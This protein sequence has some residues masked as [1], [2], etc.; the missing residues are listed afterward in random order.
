MV[1]VKPKD[2]GGLFR[3]NGTRRPPTRPYRPS[4]PSTSTEWPDRDERYRNAITTAQCEALAAELGVTP[5]ALREI[6]VGWATY[7]ELRSMRASFA[8][9]DGSYPD[10]AFTFPERDGNGRIVGLSLRATDGRKGFPAGARRGLIVP[11]TLKNQSGDVLVV[12]GATDVAGCLT[13][14]VPA[15]GRPSNASGAADLATL[16]DSRPTLIVGERDQK[17]DGRYPGRDGAKRVAQQLAATWETS[18]FWTLPPDAVK[19]IRTWLQARVAAGL[20]LAD[21]EACKTA[22]AELVSALVAARKPVKPKR[23]SQAEGVVRLAEELFRIGLSDSREPFAVARD[24]PNV[25]LMFRGSSSA[26]R[27]TLAREYRRRTGRTP[28]ASGLADA[29]VAL[30]GA[31]MECTPETVHLRVAEHDGEIV[32]DLGDADGRAV[33]VADGHWYIAEKSPILFRRTA[34]TGAMPEPKQG[35]DI[36]ALRELLNVDDESWPLVLGWLV[37]ALMP[38]IPHP[39]L[40]FGGEQGTGKSTAARMAVGLI[41]PSPA[42]LRSQPKDERDWAVTAAGSWAVAVDNVSGISGWWSDALCRAVTGDGWVARQL[43]SDAGISV[44]SFRRVIALSSIAAGALRGDLGDRL[45]IVD[46][47]PIPD[48]RRLTE[49]DLSGRYEHLLPDLLGGLLNLLAAVWK[50]LPGLRLDTLPRMADFGRVLAAMDETLSTAALAT[51]LGQRGRIAVDVIESDLVG[52]AIRTLV[53]SGPWSGT[54]GELLERIKPERTSPE[55]P[56]SPTGMAARIKR[57][58]PALRTV[59]ITVSREKIGRDRSRIYR[60]QK[61]EET[62]VRNVPPSANGLFD[63]ENGDSSRT[64]AD[65]LAECGHFDNGS[66][67]HE[68]GPDDLENAVTDG[69]D[70]AD[71]S[72]SDPSVSSIAPTA[73]PGCPNGEEP[74]RELI[75]DCEEAERCSPAWEEVPW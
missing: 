60:I 39:I 40:L 62:T 50:R 75:G 48:D 52:M 30:E 37:A 32:I 16:L 69:A 38:S 70:A 28:S 56:K 10:G 72:I 4:T 7:D 15:V 21:V 65:A 27:M 5:T 11:S 18:V 22:G 42:P 45:L 3:N 59:G 57:L 73:T 43:Y 63:A 12:E 9:D 68:T 35:G 64:P 41:D 51:Y 74:P 53:D 55:W 23:L 29:I 17:A 66:H 54:A 24:G 61:V 47:E 46:L 20:N 34:L 33:V 14:G 67:P 58:I 1:L 8:G 19:D 44:L 36:G 49:A 26:L 13:L 71:G 6:G 25:A 2:G 31:A